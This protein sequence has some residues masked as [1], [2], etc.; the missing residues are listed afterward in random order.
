MHYIN[1][2]FTYLLTCVCECGQQ[3]TM[4]HRIDMCPLTKLVIVIC[5]LYF[6]YGLLSDINVDGWIYNF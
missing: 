1:R 2:L 6:N 4:N 3:H 5:I